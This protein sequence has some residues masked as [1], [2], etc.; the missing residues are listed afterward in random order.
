MNIGTLHIENKYINTNMILKFL[1]H[2]VFLKYGMAEVLPFIS[3]MYANIFL[4]TFAA[5]IFTFTFIKNSIEIHIRH[6]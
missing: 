4:Y 3:F 6:M 1:E 5:Y 2:D